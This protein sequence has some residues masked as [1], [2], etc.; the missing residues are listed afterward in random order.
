MYTYTQTV[1]ERYSKRKME[2][3]ACKLMKVTNWKSIEF[4]LRLNPSRVNGWGIH[5]DEDKVNNVN[6][7]VAILEIVILTD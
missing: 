7:H 3:E 2:K 1:E 5:L 6:D 4:H